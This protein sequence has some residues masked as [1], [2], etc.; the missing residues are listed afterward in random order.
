[1]IAKDFGVDE[2]AYFKQW[3]VFQER[4]RRLLTDANK[5]K[6]VLG[7]LWTSTL[8]ER[9]RLDKYLDHDKYIIQIWSKGSD[10][11]IGEILNKGYKVIFSNSD[12]LYLDC[13]FSSW[14][15]NG[16][17]W[18]SPYKNWQEI[19]DN[20]ILKLARDHTGSSNF[21]K[22]VLG[23]E[24]AV[25]SEQIDEQ[26]VES[27]LW[28]RASALAERLWT[29]PQVGNFSLAEN[30]IVQHRHRL[31]QRGLGAERLKPE[32]C[33]QNERECRK[34][35]KPKIEEEDSAPEAL[36]ILTTLGYSSSANSVSI[37]ETKS[38]LLYL[39]LFNS[40]TFLFYC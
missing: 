1:M 31:V 17:N 8:T 30:R 40:L 24:A 25:W 26:T 27:R 39:I 5:G 12:K 32:F 18:C 19:Y 16:N 14:V 28:P 7:I 37:E 29:N 33:R 22:Q 11:V 23:G 9:A 10:P 36:Q 3:S 21:D 6:D 13:G 2:E 35:W 20:D 4:A 34:P 15:S 38:R